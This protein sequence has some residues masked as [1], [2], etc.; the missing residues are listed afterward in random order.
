MAPRP[1]HLL[2]LPLVSLLLPSPALTAITE[3]DVHAYRSWSS[4]QYSEKLNFLLFQEDWANLRKEF[5][6]LDANDENS[7]TLGD[8]ER[9]LGDFQDPE[10]VEEMHQ[11]CLD[12]ENDDGDSGRCDFYNYVLTR[13]EYDVMGTQFDENEWAMREETFL[14]SYQERVASPDITED[15]LEMLGMVVD[16]D[17]MIVGGEL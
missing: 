8:F 2:L 15:E 4:W 9:V 10:K 11:F 14:T 16:E 3:E 7:L 5:Q 12:A 6:A 17:G 13:G 1:Q